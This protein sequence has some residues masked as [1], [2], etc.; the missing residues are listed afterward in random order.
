MAGIEKEY[1]TLD[2]VESCWD[3]PRRD[4]VYLAE[5]GL[6]KVSVRLYGIR[7]ERDGRRSVL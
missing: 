6:L 4:L 2:E 1:F 7:I 5:N 3:M